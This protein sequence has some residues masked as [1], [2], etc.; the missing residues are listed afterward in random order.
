MPR[1]GL[2]S[3][4]LHLPSTMVGRGRLDTSAP[5]AKGGC[6][7]SKKATLFSWSGRMD[8]NTVLRKR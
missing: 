3:V 7:V 4:A 6:T 8:H 1:V 5:R 2:D